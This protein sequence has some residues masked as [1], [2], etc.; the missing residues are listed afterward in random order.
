MITAFEADG[1]LRAV[2][3]LGKTVGNGLEDKA[4]TKHS[5]RSYAFADTIYLFNEVT[6]HFMLT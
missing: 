2:S 1:W 3:Y 6:S 5:S 4:I